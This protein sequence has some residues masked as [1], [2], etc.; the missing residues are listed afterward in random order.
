MNKSLLKSLIAAAGSGAMIV[1]LGLAYAA[2]AKAAD[3]TITISG[4]TEPTGAVYWSMFD[5][6]ESFDGGAPVFAAQAR[7]DGDS[8]QATVHS[9]Q[10]GR[11]A[12]RLFHD[13]NGNGEMDTNLIGIPTEGYGFSNNAGS[14]GPASFE[15]A[16]V[17]VTDDTTITIE[18]R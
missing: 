4:I 18:V 17:T 16:A 5:S 3:V 6:E 10:P 9:L 13:A 8:V 11:Y 1:G 15:D 14:R 7:V 2:P 12:I